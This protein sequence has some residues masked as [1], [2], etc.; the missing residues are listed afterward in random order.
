VIARADEFFHDGGT[1]ESGSAGNENTHNYLP[2]VIRA[3]IDEWMPPQLKRTQ[4][5]NKQIIG[6]S[7]RMQEF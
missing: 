2:D 5:P 7:L 4:P 1:D 6:G 3:K